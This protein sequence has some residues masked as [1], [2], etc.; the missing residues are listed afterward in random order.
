VTAAEFRAWYEGR[1]WTQRQTADT[2]G[3][4]QPRV[5]EMAT[6]RAPIRPQ[7]ER[8]IAA[9]DRLAECEARR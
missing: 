3:V 6:G 9:L 4:P 1:G 7:T 8:L 2:L 5:A